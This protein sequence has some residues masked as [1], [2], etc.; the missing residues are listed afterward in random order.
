[1]AALKHHSRDW[2]SRFFSALGQ[3]RCAS[4]GHCKNV[5]G[6]A[7]SEFHGAG[8]SVTVDPVTPASPNTVDP[9]TT[10]ST[11]ITPGD[12]NSNADQ[13]CPANPQ[14]VQ[15]DANGNATV[16]TVNDNNCGK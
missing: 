5:G 3:K 16:P 10:N 8:K 11:T 13:N 4:S 14:G 9:D 6:A 2:G 12:M 15:T 1:M 7:Q